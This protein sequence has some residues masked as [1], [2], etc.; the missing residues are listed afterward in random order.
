MQGCFDSIYVSSDVEDFRSAATEF[1]NV[2]YI[3]INN[4][5]GT[6]FQKVHSRYIICRGIDGICR[7]FLEMIRLFCQRA[8]LQRLYRES[9]EYAVTFWTQ[10]RAFF[11]CKKFLNF[12]DCLQFFFSFSCPFLENE[13]LENR[14]VDSHR[15]YLLSLSLSH[16]HTCSL[17]LC[18][19]LDL[20]LSLSISLSLHLSPSLSI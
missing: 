12:C 3:P 5:D 8:L 16:T 4:T 13:L 19:S 15:V 14:R 11:P 10:D 9:T 17:S 20:S 18:L 2:H 6:K 1:Y 7:H